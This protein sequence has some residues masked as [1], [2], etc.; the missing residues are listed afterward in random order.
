MNIINP[1]YPERI[2]CLTEETTET[3]YRI[4]ADKLIT[5]ITEYTVRPEK[6]KL[7]KEIVS[8]YLDADIDK[9]L[10]MKP[11]LV[12]AWSDLQANIV[13]DLIKNGVEVYTF[14]HRSVEGILSMI[15]KLGA[16]TGFESE[17]DRLIEELNH[18]IQEAKLAA[19]K[20][21][22]KPKVYFE[23]WFSPIITGICWV[24]EI[25]EICGG[26]DIF[27][28]HRLSHNANGRIVEDDT[29]IIIR[30]P[31]IILASWCGKPFRKQT[32]LK[33]KGWD[34][35][36]AVKSNN[37]FEIDSGIILQPGPAALSDGLKI[38]TEIFTKW[39][40]KN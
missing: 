13:S 11:D 17:A 32:M 5:G 2:I 18:N 14:N 29:E 12:L 19:Q 31:D 9:I 36:N 21:K 6:A 34:N 28:E 20:L 27:E 38:L 1:K 26:E 8:R 23:E 7:E 25:I 16:I 3:L 22:R 10:D 24:S 35:I 30:N 39:S 37:I 33:R 15:L 40:E 4:G